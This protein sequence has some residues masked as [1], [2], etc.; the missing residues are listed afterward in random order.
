MLCMRLGVPFRDQSGP[1]HYPGCTKQDNAWGLH[2]ASCKGLSG[3]AQ[4]R[5][6]LVNGQFVQSHSTP[7]TMR[8]KPPLMSASMRSSR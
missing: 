2:A 4:Y 5:H 8:M 1:C 7:A 3:S 6:K